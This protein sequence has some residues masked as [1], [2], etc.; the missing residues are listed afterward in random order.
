MFGEVA[1]AATPRSLGSFYY[2]IYGLGAFGGRTATALE[3]HA[4][5]SQIEEMEQRKKAGANAQLIHREAKNLFDTLEQYNLWEF[6]R[7]YFKANIPATN[8]YKTRIGALMIIAAARMTPQQAAIEAKVSP[9]GGRLIQEARTKPELVKTAEIAA[10]IA[11]RDA[12]PA[13]ASFARHYGDVSRATEQSYK[14]VTSGNPFRSGLEQGFF[15]LMDPLKF[16]GNY[17]YLVYG[18]AALGTLAV[19]RPYIALAIGTRR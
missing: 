13:K 8:I 10:E 9:T 18:G 12:D 1:Y 17:K 19:L 14:D 15:S 5:L 7:F 11:K 16:L 6:E 4:W 2:P 3:K